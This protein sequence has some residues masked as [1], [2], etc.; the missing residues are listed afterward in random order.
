MA[1]G[2]Y[3]K[4]TV[5]ARVASSGDIFDCLVYLDPRTGPG[6]ARPG[7][8]GVI[9]QGARD[10]GLPSSYVAFLESFADTGS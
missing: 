2:R 7:Y 9:L 6:P 10:C 1:L 8:L 5:V 4:K 3:E